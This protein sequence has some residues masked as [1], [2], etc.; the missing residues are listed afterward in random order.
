MGKLLQFPTD[1]Y[2]R[3]VFKYIRLKRKHGR[4]VALCSLSHKE[5]EML[6]EATI[7]RPIDPADMKR[8]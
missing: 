6:H 4:Q 3:V 7:K 2:D 1:P 5:A 8:R